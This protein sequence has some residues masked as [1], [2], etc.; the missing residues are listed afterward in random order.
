MKRDLEALPV[1]NGRSSLLILVFADPHLLEGGKVHGGSARQHIV[2][3]QVLT[4]VNVT[5]HDAITEK[6]SH[7][8]HLLPVGFGI[9]RSFSQ[10]DGMLFRGYTKLIVEV[11]DDAMFNGIFEGKDASLALGLISYIAVFLT[12]TD[13]DTLWEEFTAALPLTS[14]MILQKAN[15]QISSRAK[16]SQ[17]ARQ[18]YTQPGFVLQSTTA[19]QANVRGAFSS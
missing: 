3:V 16:P 17:K 13:H 18:I 6:S 9:Q 11:G 14:H 8:S 10:E 4:D 5:L 7:L 15:P 2:S 1:D 19:T 12:H